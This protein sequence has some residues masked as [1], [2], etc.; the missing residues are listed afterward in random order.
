M[1][2]MNRQINGPRNKAKQDWS[3]GNTVKVGF[4]TLKIVG[5]DDARS[6]YGHVIYKLEN[7]DGT[8][9]YEFSPHEG[10]SRVQ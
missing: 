7:A 6:C 10:L 2:S 5:T 1:W 3:T 4:L 9:K 8:K